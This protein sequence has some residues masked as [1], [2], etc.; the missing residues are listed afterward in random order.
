M[1]KLHASTEGHVDDN[2]KPCSCFFHKAFYGKLRSSVTCDH[3][4]NMTRTEEPMVDLSLDLQA[5]KR[6]MKGSPA[7]NYTLSACLESFTSPEKLMAG[8]YHCSSCNSTQYKATKQLR[9][10]R[11]PAILCMQIKVSCIYPYPCR[12]GPF[13]FFFLIFFWLKKIR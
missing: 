2:D 5:K 13:F 3:C 7:A 12:I 6:D 4:G 11:L 8:V 1:D 10:K 9:I